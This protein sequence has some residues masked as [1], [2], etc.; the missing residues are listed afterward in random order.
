MPKATVSN[1]EPERFE[2]KSCPEGFVTLKRMS[3]GAFLARRDIA[4]KFKIEGAGG[5][6]FGGQM[7]MAQKAV[8]EYEFKHCIVDH[9]LDDDNGGK[10]NFQQ[11]GLL[12]NLDPRIGEE[13]S[14]LIDSMNQFEAVGAEGN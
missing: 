14:S 7:E 12:D 8:A 1:Q 6:D 13:I 4:A 11:P 9:N 3:Y 10:L 5:K 2:L